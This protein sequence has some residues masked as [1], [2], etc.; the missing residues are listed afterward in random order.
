MCTAT[1]QGKNRA[2]TLGLLCLSYGDM[3]NFGTLKASKNVLHMLWHPL[4]LHAVFA[5]D[6][7]SAQV[8]KSHLMYS[9]K[10]E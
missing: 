9:L 10:T 5:V 3:L 1:T 8:G 7:H 2:A 4:A 6:K